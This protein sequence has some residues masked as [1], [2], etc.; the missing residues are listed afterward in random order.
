MDLRQRKYGEE[1]KTLHTC[2]WNKRNEKEI[3]VEVCLMTKSQESTKDI[4][5]NWQKNY[6]LKEHKCEKTKTT[7]T[8]THTQAKHSRHIT[9]K[10]LK[11]KKKKILKGAQGKRKIASYLKFNIQGLI[12]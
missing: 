11:T 4:T 3:K 10:L 7:H 1:R 2:N 12:F 9:V 8:H 6:N 5:Y